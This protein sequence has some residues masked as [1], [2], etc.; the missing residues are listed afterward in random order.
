MNIWMINH[1]AASPA[2]SWSTRH[3]SLAAELVRRGHRVS[4]FASN[5]NRAFTTCRRI[6][7]RKPV[8]WERTAG[9]D[10]G[11]LRTP[12]YS[13]NSLGRAWNMLVFAFRILELP[14]HCSTRPDVIYGSTPSLFAALAGLAL[15]RRLGLPFVLEVRDVWPHTLIDLGLSRFHPFVVLSSVIERYLYRHADAIVALMPNAA[16]HMVERGAAPERIHWIPNGVNFDLVPPVSPPPQKEGLEVMYAGAYGSGND[17]ETILDAAAKLRQR[18][19]SAM[20]L[21]FIGTGSREAAL[22]AKR[23]ALRLDNVSFEPQVPRR[24][25][26]S[27]LSQADILVAPVMPLGVYRFGVSLNKLFDYMAVARPIVLA[28][29]ASNHPVRDAACGLECPPGDADALAEAI[30]EIASMSAQERW[31]MGLRGR[32]YAEQHHDFARLALRLESVLARTLR[33]HG[34][35]AVEAKSILRAGTGLKA[36]RISNPQ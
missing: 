20:R 33:K 32:R 8:R 2:R 3:V 6:D 18:G 25:V 14:M 5:F 4:L 35:A 1:Y 36:E 28:V 16:S 19:G 9:V 26:Y 13:D 15:A 31:E 21:R 12:E 29:R 22:V 11:W 23:A 30:L 34:N 27:L 24:E 10:I 17:P 7:G